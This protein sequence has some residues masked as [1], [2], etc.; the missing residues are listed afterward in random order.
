MD[1]VGERL[2]RVIPLPAPPLSV[3]DIEAI[4]TGWKHRLGLEGWEI[5]VA[6]DEPL[7][8]ED[9]LA[10]VVPL[11][12]YDYA[13]LRL[14]PAWPT[15][16]RRWANLTILHELIHLLTRDYGCAIGAAEPMFSPTAWTIFESRCDHEEEQLVDRL[17][18]LFFGH[19]GAI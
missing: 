2:G 9:S 4:I 14:S 18:T 12:V 8:Q 19:L 15:W 13:K 3:L 11:S 10:E 5:S 6:W 16:D 17:A 1:D 7:E